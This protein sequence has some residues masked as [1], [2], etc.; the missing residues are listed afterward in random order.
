LSEEAQPGI[1]E[2]EKDAAVVSIGSRAAPS[3]VPASAPVRAKVK[4]PSKLT[5]LQGRF[6]A[7]NLQQRLIVAAALLLFVSAIA[8]VTIS[9]RT[10]DDYRVLFSSVNERDGAAIVAALQQMN[11]PYKFTEGGAAIL[12][13]ESSVYETRLRLAGQ[14]LPKA[15][16]VGFELLENQKMGTSQFVEQVNYQRGLEGELARSISSLAQVKSARVML[17]IPKQTAFMR[18]QEK[19]TASVIVT[20]HPGRFLDSQQVAAITKLVGSSV[21]NL[22]PANVTIVDAEG[23]LLAPNAQR[24]A[25]LDN[26]QLKYV[27]ELEGALSKRIQAILEPVTGKENVRA[28]VTVDM[29]FGELERTEETFGRNSPPNQSSIRSQQ[30]NEAAT[31]STTA[32]GVPGALTNQPPGAAQAPINAPG[33]APAAGAAGAAG[34]GPQNLNAPPTSS[35]STA[36]NV[37]KDATVNYELDRA[38]QRMKSEKGQVKR[39]SAGV[40]VN[41]K[42]PTGVDKDGKPLKPTPYSAKELEQI[43]N[44]ARDALGFNERRGDSVSVA[45]IPFKIEASDEP[46]FYKQ[47][48]I[49]EI[50]KEFFKFAIILGSLGIMFF[51][52]VKPLLFPKKVDTAA[53]EQRIEEEFDEKIKAEMA[54][55]DP[56]AREKRRMEVEL[57]K[58]RQRIAEEE[59]RQQADLEKKR[60]E[61]ERQRQEEEKKQEYDELLKYAQDFVE[62]NPK[63][64][65]SIFKEWLADDAS[66]TN[67]AN[68]AAAASAPAA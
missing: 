48:G 3:A 68:A 55:M 5:E 12:V 14:G 63:V 32:S 35:G 56:K 37:K 1:Q 34:A 59:E 60:M 15:G 46:P 50:F 8:F 41:Y 62:E 36:T 33:G 64:V 27:A 29:D 58:E 51:G 18:E 52:V 6:D 43:N 39:V 16:N 20:M 65:A 28:Q 53:E 9:G 11:V 4:L 49:I 67:T 2:S 54:Q 13:P 31:P 24:L 44:L 38:I 26:T 23:S 61:E 30:T 45:N 25:G 21:P 42:Q 19:P 66:K 7:L 47:P 40:V 22:G 57:L 10:K 17:A